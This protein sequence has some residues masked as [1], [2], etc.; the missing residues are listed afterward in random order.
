MSMNHLRVEEYPLFTKI[1]NLV[2][3]LSPILQT[4]GWG[5]Y[6]FTFIIT[7]VLVIVWLVFYKRAK[8]VRPKWFS[9]YLFYYLF[10]QI[11]S[12]TSISS[13]IPLG[14]LRI[15]LVYGLFFSEIKYH[16][17]VKY[18]LRITLICLLFW[19][20]QYFSFLFTGIKILGIFTFLPI[21]LGVTDITAFIESQYGIESR[22]SS[23]FS[24]PALFAQYLLPILIILLFSRGNKKKWLIICL[25]TFCLLI[26]RSGNAL[27]GLSVI[28]LGYFLWMLCKASVAKKI[29]VLLVVPLA[30]FAGGYSYVHSEI[31]EKTLERQDQLNG[32]LSSVKSGHSGFI[33]IFRGYYVYQELSFLR[34]IIGANN[35]TLIKEAINRS[36]VSNLFM[37]D[38]LYFNTIQTILIRTGVIGL[39]IISFFFGKMYVGTNP[40]GKVSLVTLF[41]LSFVASMYFTELMYIY[42]AVAFYN[43]KGYYRYEYLFNYNTCRK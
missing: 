2:L 43:K 5:K 31:G 29:I 15:F 18:Y 10:V 25:I 38:D 35:T 7:G 20:I 12:A 32:D 39:L 34:Q 36:S 8:R 27:I 28:I 23:F 11:L 14:W 41:A 6:D 22:S 9:I 24:E 19:Y 37:E 1:I 33:R 21:A 4:Y 17:F 42:I 30:V 13:L 26:L 40:V 16:L 3:P